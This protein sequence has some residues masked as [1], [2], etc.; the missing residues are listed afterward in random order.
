[1]GLETPDSRSLQGGDLRWGPSNKRDYRGTGCV[2]I[3]L[4]ITGGSV[5]ISGRSLAETFKVP[6]W[7]ACLEA[8]GV[9]LGLLV[10]L[11]IVGC[12]GAF[13]S[14]DTLKH[15]VERWRTWKCPHCEKPYAIRNGDVVGWV[16]RVY[17]LG[18]AGHGGGSG[19]RIL[20]RECGKEGS[21][22]HDGTPDP[23]VR[24][25]D[26]ALVGGQEWAVR[27]PEDKRANDGANLHE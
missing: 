27:I 2:L 7:L 23:F 19:L 14:K 1:M 21:F 10:A 6:L 20:C 16:R 8:V 12:V 18:E 3:A 11:V 9:I 26:V 17:K 5:F 15:R 4:A 25:P 22:L 13:F 24:G